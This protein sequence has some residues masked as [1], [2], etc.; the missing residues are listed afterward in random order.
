MASEEDTFNSH[1]EDIG[2]AA[3]PLVTVGKESSLVYPGTL[4]IVY[5]PL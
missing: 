2:V 3:C 1:H 5:Y 4:M